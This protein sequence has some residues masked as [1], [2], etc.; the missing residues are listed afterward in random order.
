MQHTPIPPRRYSRCQNALI[1]ST[2]N[3]ASTALATLAQRHNLE[4][5]T[6]SARR[7]NLTFSGGC[8]TVLVVVGAD[9]SSD[10]YARK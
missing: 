6:P 4:D 3:A 7:K 5:N 2:D 1:N 10:S 9:D 8:G